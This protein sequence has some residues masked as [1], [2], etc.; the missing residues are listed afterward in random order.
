MLGAF[1]DPY[2]TDSR[3]RLE[4]GDSVL[5]YTDGVTEQNRN[6]TLGEQN[7]KSAYSN[8]PRSGAQDML[9]YIEDQTMPETEA[10]DDRAM[11]LIRVNN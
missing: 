6:A 3:I 10:H 7:L 1:H 5:A 9:S 2:L 11:V 8:C 4:A